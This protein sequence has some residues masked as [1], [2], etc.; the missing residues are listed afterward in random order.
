[1]QNM[2]AG[3]DFTKSLVLILI[4]IASLFSIISLIYIRRISLSFHGLARKMKSWQPEE[5]QYIRERIAAIPGEAGEVMRI[6]LGRVKTVEEQQEEKE[7]AK[8]D[9]SL[10]RMGNEGMTEEICRSVLPRILKD[11]PENSYFAVEGSVYSG[12]EPACNFYDYFFLDDVSLCFVIGTVPGKSVADALYMVVAQT[13]IR[14][15]LRMGRSLTE[16]MGDVNSQLYDQGGRQSASVLVGILN[17]ADGKVIYVNAGGTVPIIL[18]SG[19]RYD[20]YEAPIFAPLG[21]NEHVSYRQE[22]FR[23]KQGDRLFLYT[24]SLGEA[25]GK[26]EEAF[27]KRGLRSALNRSRSRTEGFSDVLPYVQ[28]EVRKHC[29][30]AGQLPGSYASLLLEYRKGTRDLAFCELPASPAASGAVKAFLKKI[31][32]ENGIR[33]KKY[34]R[35]LVMADELFSLCLRHADSSGDIRLESAVAPDGCLINVR[36]LAPMGGADPVDAPQSSADQS[37]VDFIKSHADY[38]HFEAGGEGGR[39]TITFVMPVGDSVPEEAKVDGDSVKA[40]SSGADG[41]GE[42]ADSTD[43]NWELENTEWGRD[44][45]KAWKAGSEE[46]P[47][48]ESSEFQR[49]EFGNITGDDHGKEQDPDHEQG[50]EWGIGRGRNRLTPLS[51]R[52]FDELAWED[53]DI[54]EEEYAQLMIRI[55][56]RKEGSVIVELIG[57]LDASAS[58]F[59]QGKLERLIPDLKELIFDLEDLKYVSSAGLRIFLMAQQ[60]M[61]DRGEMRI[62]HVREEVMEI[63]DLTGFTEILQIE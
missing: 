45:G 24:E 56:P 11:S 25:V 19:G 44:A 43:G 18:R 31:C 38:V 46:S 34:A 17:T 58:P 8:V 23:L 49:T 33:P 37:S 5:D 50:L 20:W 16:T 9:E 10:L 35:L 12:K 7:A 15:R 27:R 28:G 60:A 22:E 54:E 51:G 39:D 29:L 3:I 41:A 14:S 57:H 62:C 32:E 6:L 53:S 4:L 42:T 52:E 1:M 59:L 40:S 13:A 30:A 55:L 36:M 26:D 48:P 61:I 21:M 2:L 47:D 63:F